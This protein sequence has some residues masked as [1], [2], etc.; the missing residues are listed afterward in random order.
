[1]LCKYYN[2]AVLLLSCGAICLAAKKSFVAP[3]INRISSWSL[4]IYLFH[5]NHFWITYGKYYFYNW[6]IDATKFRI[7]PC[8][9]AMIIV[10]MAS[11]PVL[12]IVYEKTVGKLTGAFSQKMITSYNKIISQSK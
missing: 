3:T 7:F 5:S 8:V 9:F 10:Y 12:S 1:M 11:M 2:P 6:L 4:L